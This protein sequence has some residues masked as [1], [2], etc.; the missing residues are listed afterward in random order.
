MTVEKKVEQKDTNVEYVSGNEH[1]TA[2]LM[3]AKLF[4]DKKLDRIGVLNPADPKQ[5]WQVPLSDVIELMRK[6]L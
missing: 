3:P 6:T 1:D 4:I 2:Y 5:R